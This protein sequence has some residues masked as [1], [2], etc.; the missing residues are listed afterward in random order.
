V[1]YSCIAQTVTAARAA[2]DVAE[3]TSYCTSSLHAQ[4]LYQP[5]LVAT[6]RQ[7]TTFLARELRIYSKLR[8][9]ST[10]PVCN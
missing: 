4:A 9:P 3:L 6:D 7:W 5:N 1:P 10:D 2:G 8:P